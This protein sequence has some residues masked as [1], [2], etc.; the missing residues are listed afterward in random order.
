MRDEAAKAQQSNVFL[1]PVIEEGVQF[2]SGIF[3]DHEYIRFP[4][5]HIADTFIKLLEGINF[6]KQHRIESV[7]DGNDTAA[8]D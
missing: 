7:A 4:S 3:A 6:V 2:E 8:N 1:V 5:G